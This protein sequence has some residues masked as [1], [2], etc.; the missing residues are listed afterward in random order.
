MKTLNQ[1]RHMPLLLPLLLVAMMALPAV[2]MAAPVPLGTTSHF[3]VLSGQG[4]TNTGATWIGGDAGGDVG[5]YPNPAFTGQASV[6]LANGVPHLGDSVALSAKNDLITA[7]DNAAGRTPSIIGTELGGQTLIPGVYHSNSGTFEIA[8]GQ[9]LTLNAQGDPDG[10]FVFQTDT[11]LVTFANS[12]VHLTGSAQYCRV[13]WK[14]DTAT[15][16]TYSTFVGHIFALTS[17]Q[18]QHRATVQGQLLARNGEVTLD[19]NTITNGICETVTC[20]LY[21]SPS[22]RD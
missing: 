6:T 21:T 19:T 20:L 12:V 22:P 18:A 4:I 17:I 8:A 1:M 15:L 9:T 7:Y 16:G 11:T 13:F 14:V 10:V 3:A 2:S 5:S